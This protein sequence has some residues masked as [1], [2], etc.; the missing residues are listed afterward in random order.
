MIHLFKKIPSKLS[1][2]M[3]AFDAGARA[4]GDKFS[5]GIAHMLEHMIFKGTEK[6]SYLDIPKEIGYLGGASN[7][8]TSQ[9]LVNFHI[10]VPYENIE[11]AMEILSDMVFN[12]TFPEEEFKKEREVV[13]EEERS[14]KDDIQ[15]IMYDAFCEEFFQNRLAVPIIGTPESID[16]FTLKELK[17]FHK[18][19]YSRS[20]A[21][22]SLSSNHTKKEA[23]RLLTKHFGKNTGKISHPVKTTKPEFGEKRGVRVVKPE[24][25][26]SYVWLCYPG[27][28]IT[29]GNE[30]A[31]DMMQSIFGQGMDSRLFTEVREERGLVY[32]I[33]AGMAAYRDTGAMLITFSTRPENVEEA[34]QIIDEQV[35][36]I[37]NELVSSE[38][39]ERA[40]NKYRSGSYAL[41]ESSFALA[42]SNMTR[43]FYDLCSV[44][45]LDRNADS[46]TP[47]EVRTVAKELFD[48][49][50]RLI[51][52]CEADVA[53]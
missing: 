1:T 17:K 30:A 39:L 49:S 32:S 48:K 26:H 12:S 38:E 14:S 5:P 44:E 21:I 50:K 8:Y 9:E 35:E 34:I 19:F 43:R 53:R 25:E 7:A 36:K 40:R 45:E 16:G 10:T 6:R 4:E 42:Q 23:K 3:I 47:E 37:Q 51:L 15:S 13:Q 52:I 33:Y 46:V 20:N 27:H 41:A 18:K 31:E 22:V 2:I 11:E 29:E 28:N 24:L